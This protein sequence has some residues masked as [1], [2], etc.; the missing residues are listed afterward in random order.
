MKKPKKNIKTLTSYADPSH[1]QLIQS[2]PVNRSL[3]QDPFVHILLIL[4]TG[5]VVYFNSI[6]VPFIFDDYTYL[7]NN[8]VIKS[9]DCF[10]DTQKVFDYAIF[11]DLK[12]NLILRPVAYFTFAA[13]YSL[14]GLNLFGYHLVNL[15][16]HI[17]CGM[18]VYCFFAQ[19]LVFPTIVVEERPYHSNGIDTTGHL[20]LFAAL[21]FICH[22]LQTQAVTYIIQRFVPLSTFFYLAALVLYVQFRRESTLT[23]RGLTY[24]LSLTATVLAM[25]SKE[26]AITLPVIIALVE[27]MLFSGNILPRLARLVPFLV[28]MAIIPTKLMQLPSSVTAGKTENIADAINLVNASGTSSWDYLMTQ[29]GVITT[30]IRLLIVP[31]GQNFDYDY[32]LQ[33]SFFRLE[34]LV[35]LALLLVIFVTGLHLLS[36]AGENRL[37]KIIALGIFWFFITLSVESSIV[38]IEDLIFEHRAYLPSVGFIVSLLTSASVIFNRFTGKLMAQSKIATFLLM[39]IIVGLSTTAI[40]RIKVWQDEVTFW[41]D[42]VKKSPNKARAYA[43]LGGALIQQSKY[44]PND[45]EISVMGNMV[46][47]KAGSE[48]QMHAAINAYKEAIRIDPKNS[49]RHQDLAV[50]LMLQK[51]YDEALRSL[52]KASELK[53]TSPIPYALRG[54]LFESKKDVVR[55]RQEYLE[56]IKINPSYHVPHVKL[57]DIYTK[58]GNVQD[59]IKELELVM[60][61]FPD[62]TVRKKL[63][64]LNNR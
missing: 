4:F 9:F 21:L 57:A 56:A 27:F 10:P 34:V 31:I 20:P 24:T 41:N 47:L 59:A 54:E 23:A 50:A 38:P 6:N 18:L 1:A 48:K 58:E 55:A 15:L 8:P 62:E 17:G 39:S 51:N 12:N 53:P 35:P 60:R 37:Y 30:Y 22:P 28:T 40:A 14:H 7:A 25:E 46:M 13:N 2:E 5:F 3:W 29:F 43:G 45:A 64:R 16:L 52:S 49:V 63:D 42:V 36:R 61:I 44:I 11:Q 26:I 33:Q 19:L 32:A